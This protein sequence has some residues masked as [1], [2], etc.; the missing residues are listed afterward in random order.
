MNSQSDSCKPPNFDGKIHFRRWKQQ[1]EFWLYTLGLH[2]A[3]F[4]DSGS[5]DF[6]PDNLRRLSIS[7]IEQ[8]SS[9][10]T[11]AK[12]SEEIDFQCLNRILTI[13]SDCLY[14]KYCNYKT[15]KDIWSA[16]EKNMVPTTL[17]GL[18]T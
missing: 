1:A 2:T 17:L 12:N 16:L 8:T 3:L 9:S 6:G 7:T 18:V 11:P 13:L 4:P 15:A 14:D 10:S 5:S